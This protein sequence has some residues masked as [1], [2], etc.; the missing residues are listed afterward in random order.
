M[1]RDSTL[2]AQKFLYPSIAIVSRAYGKFIQ[3]L[4]RAGEFNEIDPDRI[5]EKIIEK[6]CMSVLDNADDVFGALGD[7]IMA[8]VPAGL[9]LD[10]ENPEDK[11][12]LDQL[13]ADMCLDL[14]AAILEVNKGFFTKL[15]RGVLDSILSLSTKRPKK[16]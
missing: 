5:T 11:A 10:P 4:H 14:H 16:I 7:S 12:K 15:L 3:Q 2:T 1:Q 9:R 8:I 13:D 6:A